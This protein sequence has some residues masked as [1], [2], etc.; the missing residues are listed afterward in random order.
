MRIDLGPEVCGSLAE[1]RAR[2]WMV[3]DGLGGYAMGTVASLRTRRYHGLLV[4]ATRPPIGRMLSLAA[5]DP[6]LVVG[7]RRIRLAVHDWASGA[8]DPDGHVHLSSFALID[9]VPRW[10][11]TVGDV[12]V[13]RELAMAR[14]RP[15]VGV[16]HRV[17]RAQGPVRLE[18]DA[19][20]TWRDVHGERFGNGPP[21]VE[22]VADGFVF[23]RA[24][25]VRG[26]APEAAGEWYR[27]V[28]CSEEEARGL[29]P[30]EDLFHAGRF[31]AD[32]DPGDAIGVEA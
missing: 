16:V 18:L 11:W 8:T 2:E 17:V 27:D 13:E 22:R 19:L 29:N 5:L 10:R 14:G 15:G 25:R 28:R 21:V 7:D 30:V 1:A 26:P 4:A 12:V 6:V 23:E 24:F 20:C 3:A 9:G 31:G 32:L